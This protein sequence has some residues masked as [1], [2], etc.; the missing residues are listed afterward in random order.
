MFLNERLDRI[1][2][3]RL[4]HFVEASEYRTGRCLQCFHR[5]LGL[6]PCR[7]C[8]CTCKRGTQT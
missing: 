7:R 4:L 1:T 2:H 8:C 6:L 3:L 5:V